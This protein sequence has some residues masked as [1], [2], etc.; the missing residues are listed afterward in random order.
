MLEGEH[1]AGPAD[2]GLN[3]VENQQQPVPSRELAQI[4]KKGIRKWDDARFPLNRFEHDC[5]CVQSNRTLN[6]P[7]VIHGN[8]EEALDF[9]FIEFLELRFPRCRH[10][11]ESPA[12]ESVF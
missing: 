4:A 6:S 12:M 10:R 2:S 7:D 8:V 9:R 1:A 3:L 11:C 5:R